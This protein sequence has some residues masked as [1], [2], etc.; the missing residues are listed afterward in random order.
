VTRRLPTTAW[1]TDMRIENNIL[2]LDGYARSA[3][4]LVRI[5]GQSPMFSGV[6]LSAPVTRDSAK[7]GERFQLRMKIEK[8]ELDQMPGRRKG[9]G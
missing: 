4:E 6:A 8:I 2:W 1:L 7:A 3:S 9:D 5:V